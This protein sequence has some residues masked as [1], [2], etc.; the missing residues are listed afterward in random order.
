MRATGCSIRS[1]VEKLMLNSFYP[2]CHHD[3]I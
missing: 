3:I 1:A 2:N